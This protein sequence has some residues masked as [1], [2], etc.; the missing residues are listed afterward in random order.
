MP[1]EDK[2]SAQRLTERFRDGRNRPVSVLDP[3][4]LYRLHRYDVIPAESLE[5]MV[6][7]IGSGWVAI[8][9]VLFIG[10][11]SL[12]IVCMGIAHVDKWGGGFRV[13]P[14]ELGLW[15]VLLAILAV[16]VGLVWFFARSARLKRVCRVM[17][18]HLRC[19][20]CGYDLRQLPVDSFDGAT[21]C[22]EC[23]CAWMID[24]A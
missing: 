11:W 8:G 9:R 18:K 13:H 3:Y 14:R 16:N 21:I 7:E 6:R 17:L 2:N 4:L 19:P 23:G 15:L 5:A 22:P 20:H 24:G 10:I 12:V 1:D